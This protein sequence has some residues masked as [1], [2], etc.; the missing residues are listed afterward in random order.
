MRLK[1]LFAAGLDPWRALGDDLRT[2]VFQHPGATTLET[3]ILTG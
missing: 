1:K 3:S 2:L